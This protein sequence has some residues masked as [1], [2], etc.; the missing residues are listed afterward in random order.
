MAKKSSSAFFSV[1][2]EFITEHAR[3]R[4]AEGAYVKA[5]DLLDC[6]EGATHEQKQEIL[7][8][9]KKLVG[10]ND[11]DLVDDDWKP[12]EGIDYP[13]YKEGMARGSN[14][15]ELKA[16]QEEKAWKLAY[17]EWP[18]VRGLVFGQKQSPN[19]V[20]ARVEKLVGK[21]R[22]NHIFREVQDDMMDRQ[23]NSYKASKSTKAAA[24]SKEV[25]SPA[26]TADPLAMMYAQ[27]QQNL[28]MAAIENGSDLGG[29][30]SVDAMMNRGSTVEVVLDEHM[31]SASGWLLP[32][33]NYYGCGAMEHIGLAESLLKHIGSKIGDSGNAELI[34]E[35]MGWVKIS[36]S[37]MGLYAGCKK[38][39]TKKQF[40]KLWDYSVLHKKDYEE[41]VSLLK[42]SK[43]EYAV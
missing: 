42:T 20:F 26:K 18:Y 43:H 32:N 31:T 8:G 22:A 40:D 24:E 21:E 41:I 37:M 28:L 2:G 6:L 33:G 7:F 27:A 13:S 12:G 11:V 34:A 3:N 14:W 39:P 15:Q 35:S 30:P 23:F 16:L 38:T 1:S 9:T 5:M 19:P 17:D 25:Y 29:I 4:W 10:V 36:R